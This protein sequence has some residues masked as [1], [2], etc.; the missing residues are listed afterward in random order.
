MTA[1]IPP[2]PKDIP[3]LPSIPGMPATQP[4]RVPATAVVT[5]VR[6]PL[7]AAYRLL[8]ALAAAA[9]VTVDLWLGSPG[10]LLSHFTIQS[11]ILLAVVLTLQARRAWTARHPL[12]SSWTGATLLYVTIAGAV[13]HLLL[14]GAASPFSMTGTPPTGWQWT[15]NQILH[16]AIPAAVLLDWL[17]LTPPG[18]LH[19]RQTAVWMLYPLAY[20][21]FSLARGELLPP[22]TPTRYLY[23]FLDVGTHGYR[24]VLADALLLGLAF[25]ALAA[26]LVAVDHTRPDLIRHRGKT[27]FR[28]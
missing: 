23:P 11:E 12:P 26:L 5:P 1:P 7:V 6:R 18:R 21:A 16:T 22:D 4:S 15:A 8:I 27:G 25:C 3:D 2:I 10:R 20:L 9:A 24:D 14:T 19:L 13:Y 28:L 17:L